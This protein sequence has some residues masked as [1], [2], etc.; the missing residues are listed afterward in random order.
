M[1]ESIILQGKSWES[2]GDFNT[3]KFNYEQTNY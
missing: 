2:I 3:S 1:S